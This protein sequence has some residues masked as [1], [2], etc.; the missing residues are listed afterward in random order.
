MKLIESPINT[1][2]NLE[3]VF[4]NVT[5]FLFDHSAIKFYKIY[6]LDRIQIIYVDT[7]DYLGLVMI[8]SKKK[9][10]KS[11]VDFAIHRLLK[12]TRDQVKVDVGVKA[13]MEAA[14]IKFSAPRKD[15]IFVKMPV[16]KEWS[17]GFRWRASS[18]VN[19]A[20]ISFCKKSSC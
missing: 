4:P 14:G 10:K 18:K 5:K 20:K 3:T 8:D 11:E 6:A 1:N 16:A 13:R 17:T 2:L 12:T 7:Y 19:L 9:I 15:I